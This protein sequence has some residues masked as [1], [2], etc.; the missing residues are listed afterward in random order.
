MLGMMV[1]FIAFYATG[2]GNI[3]WVSSVAIVQ[4]VHIEFFSLSKTCGEL[5]PLE[6][7]GV[8]SAILAGGVWS[9]NIVI[10]ATFLSI[11]NAVRLLATFYSST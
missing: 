8:G 7:R 5:F 6:L 1:V 10:S 9:S 3:T 4:N 11:M 2:S